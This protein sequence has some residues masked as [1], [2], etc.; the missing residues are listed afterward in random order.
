MME[1]VMWFGPTTVA[2]LV[3]LVLCLRRLPDSAA[4]GRTLLGGLIGG[5]VTLLFL[6]AL[7]VQGDGMVYAYLLSLLVGTPLGGFVAYG[8]YTTGRAQREAE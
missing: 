5:V 3:L 7:G 1:Y 4:L 2:W 6:L 8:L